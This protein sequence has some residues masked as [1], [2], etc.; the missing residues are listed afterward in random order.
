MRQRNKITIPTGGLFLIL[1]TVCFMLLALS[2]VTGF[3][4]GPVQTVA[5]Y[6]FVPMQKGLD[7]IGNGITESTEDAKTKEELLAENESLT[8]QV[9]ELT[10]QLTNMQLQQEELE[11]LE[12]LHDLAT[13]YGQYD[14]VGAH[15]IA[16]GTSN[17][18]NTFTIDKGTN[19]GVKVNM[20]IISGSGLVGIVTEVGPSYA[21]VRS[22]IDDNSSVSSMILAT[23]DNCIVSGDL[24]LMTDSNMIELTDLEDPDNEVEVG[25]AVVTS[26]ISSKF[27]PG[28]LIGYVSE[29]KEDAN[30]LTKSGTI[31][32]VVDFKH[33]QEVLVILELKETGN[34]DGN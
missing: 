27:L 12:K 5:N 4:G 2:Y 20:N 24:E 1:I 29:L 26:N 28:I 19:D 10:T 25:T 21:V 16:K 17:W 22:V 23:S 30:N 3:S 33:L 8:K 15:V 7:F 34:S 9:E 31:T 6:I 14:T 13:D 32:P 11:R 18:F